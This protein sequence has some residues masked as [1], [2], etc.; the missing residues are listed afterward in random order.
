MTLKKDRIVRSGAGYFIKFTGV[1]N[2]PELTSDPVA[3]TRMARSEAD[4]VASVMNRKGFGAE[5]VKVR[6]GNVWQL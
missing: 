2:T 6:Y 1:D 5:L 3:A 4:L